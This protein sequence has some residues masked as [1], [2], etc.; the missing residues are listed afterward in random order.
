MKADING[1]ARG[2]DPHVS[3]KGISQI[4][5][6]VVIEIPEGDE[7]PYSCSSGYFRNEIPID[8]LREAVVNAIIH[9]LM[10]FERR[11][12]ASIFNKLNHRAQRVHWKTNVNLTPKGNI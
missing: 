1:L 3:I 7:K 12:A 9:G 4:K 10:N 11:V 5:S 6:V 8:A 2:C